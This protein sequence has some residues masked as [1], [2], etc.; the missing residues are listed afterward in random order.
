MP[1]YNKLEVYDDSPDDIIT[2]NFLRYDNAPDLEK[3]QEARLSF[4]LALK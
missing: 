4:M 1:F 3:T 2:V